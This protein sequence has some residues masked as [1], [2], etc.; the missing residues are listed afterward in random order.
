MGHSVNLVL[1][2]RVSSNAQIIECTDNNKR[3]P[4]L[5]IGIKP[6]TAQSIYAIVRQIDCALPISSSTRHRSVEQL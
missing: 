6:L 2:S 4:S 5:F 3:I 1:F